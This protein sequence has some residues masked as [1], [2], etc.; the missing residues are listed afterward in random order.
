M[1]TAANDFVPTVLCKILTL[2]PRH[3]T[4]AISAQFPASTQD[5]KP[6]TSVG[7][8]ALAKAFVPLTVKMIVSS[9]LAVAGASTEL[10][11]QVHIKPQL[12]LQKQAS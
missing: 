1:A 5:K 8:A 6:G 12:L 2:Q 11:L 10:L 4:A 7:L 9:L 3:S